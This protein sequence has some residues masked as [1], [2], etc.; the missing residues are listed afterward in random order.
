[1]LLPYVLTL[2]YFN[3]TLDTHVHFWKYANTQEF[4]WIG[5][6]AALLRRSWLPED[7]QP[8]LQKNK[9]DGCIAVQAAQTIAETDFLLGLA[10][11]HGFIKGVVGWADLLNQRIDDYLAK[12]TQNAK[13]KGVRHILQ[14]ERD[15]AFMVCKGFKRGIEALGKYNLTYDLVIYP[16][17]L[18][19][20]TELVKEFPDQ[21]FVIDHLAKP[22]I[23][24]GYMQP[25]KQHMLQL[26]QFPNLYVKVSGMITEADWQQWTPAH[27][28]PYID[29]IVETFGTGRMMFGSDW[30]VC[31]VAGR[32]KQV[33]DVMKN[34]TDPFSEEEKVAIMGGN[35]AAFYN[36]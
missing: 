11:E 22:F 2:S 25:W 10:H 14:G 29:T 36:L 12:A 13:L 20:V 24:H 16:K 31:N 3:M 27:L 17:H 15:N 8:L 5:D 23:K 4:A 1:M 18:P 33:T 35:G 9:I 32:Y 19:Y 30:P 34:Y 28:Y 7:L 21:K 26:S 6:E